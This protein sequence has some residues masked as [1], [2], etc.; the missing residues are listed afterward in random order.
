MSSALPAQS[1][2]LTPCVAPFLDTHLVIALLGFLQKN[3]VLPGQ[4]K[5]VT[6]SLVTLLGKTLMVDFHTQL[7]PETAGLAE[8]KAAAVRRA[9]ELRAECSRL[10]AVVENQQTVRQLRQEW[11]FTVPAL[12]E[13]FGVTA[14][15]VDRLYDLAMHEYQCGKYSVAA[16]LLGSYRHLV[17]HAE[18]AYEAAWG[19]LA[20][21]ILSEGWDAALDVLTRLRE[22]IDTREYPTPSHQLYHRA[23]LLHH[24]L[25]VYSRVPQGRN[26]LI[27]LFLSEKY[28]NAIQTVCPHLLRYLAVAAITSKRR[29]AVLK[30]LVR[31]VQAEAYTYRDPL[32]RFLEALYVSFDFDEAQVLLKE[33]DAVVKADFF[34]TG[35]AGDFLEN[36]Q[37]LVFEVFCRIFNKIEIPTLGTK[38]NLAP[39]AAEKWIVNL[40]RNARLEAKIDSQA[41]CVVMQTN[42]AGNPCSLVV[43]RT[44]G[45]TF[46]SNVIGNYIS[47][48]VNELQAMNDRVTQLQQQQ[49]K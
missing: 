23:W 46:R 7:A 39:E 25:F 36:A 33:C 9:E 28:L 6:A 27:D 34:L 2:D 49:R 26:A 20:A 40:I 47:K 15:M 10:L 11:A 5:E 12:E 45:L 4:D 18:K 44:K 14:E 13:R 32:T 31:V 8:R 1:S 30:D 38:L 16:E 37:L 22:I 24:S 19:Q 35:Q 21:L 43:E 41:N 17:P 29:R 42:E 48:K 3:R